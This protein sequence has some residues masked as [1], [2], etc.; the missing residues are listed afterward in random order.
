M[1]ATLAQKGLR[2]DLRVGHDSAGQKFGRRDHAEMMPAGCGANGPYRP[3]PDMVG[4][5]F[6]Q[7]AAKLMIVEKTGSTCGSSN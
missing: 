6:R 3:S 5:V 7:A 4:T 2:R 1:T